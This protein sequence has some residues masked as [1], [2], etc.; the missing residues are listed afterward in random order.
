[1]KAVVLREINQKIEIDDVQLSQSNDPSWGV[2]DL[3]FSAINRR[4][5]YISKGQYAKIVTP[6]V[7]GSDGAG[8]FNGQQ[9]LINP[10]LNWTDDTVAQPEDYNILGMPLNGTFAEKVLVPISNI[11]PIPTHLSLEEAAALPLAGLTA[12][13]V[14]MNKCRLQPGEKVLVTGAGGGVSTFVIQFAMSIGAEVYITSGD[15]SKLKYFIELG[16]AGA[17]NYKNTDWN[18]ELKKMAGGFDVIIDSAGGDFFGL[19]LGLANP[20]ARIGVYGGT[21][22]VV[23]NFSPQMLFWKQLNIYG[24]TMGSNVDFKE[25]LDFVSEHQ[26]H[27]IIHDTIEMEHVNTFFEKMDNFKTLGKIVIKNKG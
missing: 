1:M 24:S 10:S 17:V 6:V 9:V 8:I 2:V 19:L 15:E 13:R 25:M 18:K 5:Y 4:D 14:L 7:L 26:I 3:H 16:V 23:R 27:P 20:G 21:L 12:Y 11:H 22:G